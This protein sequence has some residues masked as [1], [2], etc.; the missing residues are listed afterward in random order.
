MY[1][2]V[3]CALDLI[4][5]LMRYPVLFGYLGGTL[6]YLVGEVGTEIHSYF[7]LP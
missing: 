3:V 4:I 1:D 7:I 5:A 6:F 2:V